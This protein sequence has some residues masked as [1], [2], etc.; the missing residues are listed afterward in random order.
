[1]MMSSGS[2]SLLLTSG[3]RGN[4][5][6]GRV[7]AGCAARALLGAEGGNGCDRMR[8]RAPLVRR[9]TPRSILT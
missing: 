6:A 4:C 8:V 9:R 5:G 2:T 1:M 3:Y 7:R